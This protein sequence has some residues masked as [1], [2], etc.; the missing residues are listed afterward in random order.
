MY[1]EPEHLNILIYVEMLII[2]SGQYNLGKKNKIRWVMLPNFMTYYEDTII[3]T[4]LYECKNRLMGKWKTPEINHTHA[5]NWF[6]TKIQ[7]IQWEKG[8]S[9]Q[10][11]VQ[12]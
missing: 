9:F 6:S 4:V 11:M 1:E 5:I 3:K 12:E 7:T 2:K 8:K 10:H